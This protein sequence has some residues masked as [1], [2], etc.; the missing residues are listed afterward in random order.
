MLLA[1]TK[2]KSGAPLT[3][4]SEEALQTLNVDSDP[5]EESKSTPQQPVKIVSNAI[6]ERGY[7]LRQSYP[8]P[9]HGGT[10]IV[11]TIPA[12]AKVNIALY[13]MQGR[14]MRVLAAGVKDKG[15]HVVNLQTGS[16]AKGIY[17]Y[18]MTSDRF[19]ET[20][21]LIIQ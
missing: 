18:R 10:T 4:S 11:Y 8:N 12:K 6:P 3:Y 21:K 16:L 15:R 14:L 2:Y 20:K 19:S 7:S 13:D 5:C 17:Y 9:T 1:D